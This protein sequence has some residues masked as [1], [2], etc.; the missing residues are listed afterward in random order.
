MRGEESPARQPPP[1]IFL[2]VPRG[3]LSDQSQNNPRK[4]EK[5]FPMKKFHDIVIYELIKGLGGDITLQEVYN[6]IACELAL[7]IA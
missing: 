2:G 5:K 1:K 4:Q 7:L 3:H 6:N